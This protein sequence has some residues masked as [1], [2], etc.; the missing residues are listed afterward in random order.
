MWPFRSLARRAPLGQRG[1]QLAKRFLKR[2]GLRILARNYRCPAGEADLIVL[3]KGTRAERGADTI[4]FVEV[5]TRSSDHYTDPEAAVNTAKRQRMR[6]V[7]DYYLTAHDTDDFSVRFD[8]VAIVLGDGQRP[9]V[10]H[11]RDAF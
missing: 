10:K 9:D 5:K 4:A 8:V 3:D 6:N 7:A 1:E 11:I 2:S